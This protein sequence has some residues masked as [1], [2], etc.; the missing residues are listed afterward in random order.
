[1]YYDPM[2]AK[3]IATAES[4]PAAID[5]LLAALREFVIEGVATNIPFLLALLARD[6][7]RRGAIDTA[8]LDRERIVVDARASTG[9]GIQFPALAL[10]SSSFD[11]WDGRQA[12]KAEADVDATRRRAVSA[13]GA[14]VTAPMPATIVSVAVKAGDRVNKG[15]TMLVL[16]AMKMELPVR[17]PGDAVVKAVRCR[18]GEI[19]AADAVLVEFEKSA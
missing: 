19:V 6:E 12:A 8:F 9:R 13:A 14:T 15:D 16:E 10:S 11:P 1:V 5:R 4:R 3:V 7:F 17:A 18:P 2:I